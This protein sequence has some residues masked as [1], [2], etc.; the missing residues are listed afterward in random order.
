MPFHY[1]DDSE[2]V[3]DALPGDIP[4]LS[5]ESTSSSP[6]ELACPCNDDFSE[7]LTAIIDGGSRFNQGVIDDDPLISDSLPSSDPDQDVPQARIQH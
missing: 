3:E 1:E 2:P 5:Y 7:N 4:S 6:I